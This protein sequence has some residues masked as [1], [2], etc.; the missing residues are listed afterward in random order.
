MEFME[1]GCKRMM[2]MR[3]NE[4]TAELGKED[5]SKRN[6][7]MKTIEVDVEKMLNDYLKW[8]F[9]YCSKMT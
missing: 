4:L 6:A 2:E 8:A 1:S 9:L 5:P 7:M 3:V